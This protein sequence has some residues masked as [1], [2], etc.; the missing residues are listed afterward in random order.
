MRF[1]LEGCEITEDTLLSLVE[2]DLAREPDRFET[3]RAF[4]RLFKSWADMV[5]VLPDEA[6][7][8]LHKCIRE[9]MATWRVNWRGGKHGN[10]VKIGHCFVDPRYP[11]VNPE[12]G[13]KLPVWSVWE[14]ALLAGSFLVLGKALGMDEECLLWARD[15]AETVCRYGWFEQQPEV[16]GDEPVLFCNYGLAYPGQGTELEGIPLA[17]DEY[18]VRSWRVLPQIRPGTFEDPQ[19][20]YNGTVRWSATAAGVVLELQRLGLEVTPEASNRA[21]QIV[22]VMGDMYERTASLEDREWACILQ[23]KPF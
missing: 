8:K 21:L 17:H 13:E 5:L 3:E 16:E 2:S 23:P 12:T 6:Q 7:Q 4:A 20:A 11:C 9:R 15:L 18:D 19:P 10:P 1:A 14:H 22:R